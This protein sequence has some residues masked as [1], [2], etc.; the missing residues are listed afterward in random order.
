MQSRGETL[1]QEVMIDMYATSSSL[2]I[3][4]S[5]KQERIVAY[6]S[7]F[8][9]HIHFTGN[10]A[11]GNDA[12]GNEAPGNEAPVND[13]PGNDAPENDAP[14]NDAPVND[15]PVNDAPGN[16]APGNRCTWE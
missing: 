8:I 9:L 13:T 4:S 16:E 11:P 6:F 14:V 5:I 12:P 2:V 15:A 1:L 10:D 7:S 3:S